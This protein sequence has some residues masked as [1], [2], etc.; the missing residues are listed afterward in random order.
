MQSGKHMFREY[1]KNFE[2]ETWEWFD[3]S[4]PKQCRKKCEACGIWDDK[5]RK[6][7]FI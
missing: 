4:I 2:L 6:Y 7:R 3:I 1:N 5:L